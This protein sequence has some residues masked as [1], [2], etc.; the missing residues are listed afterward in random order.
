MLPLLMFYESIAITWN[1][2]D[3]VL[4]QSRKRSDVLN[5]YGKAAR[6]LEHSMKLEAAILMSFVSFYNLINSKYD[7]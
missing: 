6:Y 2:I 3:N 7:Y 4:S 1:A 5:L